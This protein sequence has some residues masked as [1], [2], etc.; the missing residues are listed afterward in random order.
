MK[1]NDNDTNFLQAESTVLFLTIET[2]IAM[3]ES[4]VG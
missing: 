4:T 1:K 2:G 3:G